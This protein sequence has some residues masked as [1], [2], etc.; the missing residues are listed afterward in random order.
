VTRHGLPIAERF[1]VKV[2]RQEGDEC[3]PWLAACNPAGY[4]QFAL[5]TGRFQRAHRI[6]YELSNGP[7]P[8][9][10]VVRHSCDNPPCC[11]PS[12][13]QP[14]T[15]QDNV[16]D[17]V[18][19]GRARGGRT[20]RPGEANPNAKLTADQVSEIVRRRAAGETY[21]SLARSFPVSRS[22]LCRICTGKRWA[23]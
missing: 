1:W 7:I 13:L 4:G 11:N 9:G 5:A 10:M 19:R 16:H 23:A 22:Q 21:T 6:A 2:A 17:M 8:A 15:V 20:P 3:W 18:S 14:G 12:H